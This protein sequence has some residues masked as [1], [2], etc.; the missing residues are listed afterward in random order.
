MQQLTS[1][2]NDKIKYAVMLR[3]SAAFRREEGR[4]LLEGARLCF[5]A[6][7]SGVTVLWS[8][9]TPQA[10][11]TYA[12]YVRPLLAP[13]SACYCINDSVSRTLA[14]TANPQGVFCVCAMPKQEAVFLSPQGVYLALERV[15][16]PQN[17]GGI[18]R[19]S[20][21]LGLDGL[22]L[23]GGCD[24]FQPKALRAAMGSA[25]RV[26]LLE[27]RDLPAA[28]QKAQEQG[29]QLFAAVPAHNAADIRSLGGKKGLIV[30]IGNEGSGVSKEVLSLCR[31]ITVPMQGRAESLNAAAA[32]AIIGWEL[33]NKT[34]TAD[35]TVYARRV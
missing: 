17:L 10:M 6:A 4:F 20:E 35:K 8:F 15:Q 31:S 3:E 23:S 11:D 12:D 27:V 33:C 14:D 9:L 1:R 26:P 34:A 25:L 30:V 7:Q 18:L 22:L 29:L 2:T 24:R 21:A 19:S 16:D 13:D 28:L 32:A 5:D